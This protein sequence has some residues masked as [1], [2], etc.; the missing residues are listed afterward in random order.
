[1]VINDENIGCTNHL[2]SDILDIDEMKDSYRHK[3]LRKRL[4]REVKAKGISDTRILEVIGKIPRHFFLDSGFDD[5]AYKD[6]AFPIGEDQTISQPYTVAYQTQLLKVHQKDRI[7]EIGTGSGY[8]A[9][10]LYELGAR[11]YSIERQETLYVRTKGLLEKLGYG[12]IRTFLG[13]GFQGLE[14]YAPFDK[15]LLTAAPKSMPETLISQL[16]SGGIIVFPMGKKD[17]AQQM[18]RI[19]NTKPKLTIEKFDYFRF[20]PMVKGVR[21]R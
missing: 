16:E 8:Q 17:D 10:V 1:M 11:V 4:V 21:K 6:V 20:V 3:G 5:W 12:G 2:W 9:A 18:I 19:T 13:D 14:R 7:M 15:I